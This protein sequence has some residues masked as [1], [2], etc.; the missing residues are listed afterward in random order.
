MKDSRFLSSVACM[1]IGKEY[2]PLAEES[3]KGGKNKRCEIAEMKVKRQDV[4]ATKRRTENGGGDF[5]DGG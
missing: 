3:G 4:L 1:S 2:Q 5:S